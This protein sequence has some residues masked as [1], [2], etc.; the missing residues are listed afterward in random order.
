MTFLFKAARC[1]IAYLKL[2]ESEIWKCCGLKSAE[3][4]L[5]VLDAFYNFSTLIKLKGLAGG[6]W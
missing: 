2:T 6:Q 4:Q 5:D 1:E 3:R